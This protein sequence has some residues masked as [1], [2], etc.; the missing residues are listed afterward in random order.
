[1]DSNDHQ[2][3]IMR[4]TTPVLFLCLVLAGCGGEEGG[5]GA[6]AA[7]DLSPMDAAGDIA[8]PDAREVAVTDAPAPDLPDSALLDVPGVDLPDGV[9]ADGSPD[10]LVSDSS[11]GKLTVGPEGGALETDEGVMFEVPAGAVDEP[12]V[13]EV[14]EQEDVVFVSAGFQP[15][16]AVFSIGPSGTVFAVPVTLT[17]PYDAG[18]LPADATPD[19]VGIYTRAGPSAHWEAL[20]GSAGDGIVSTEIDHLSDFAAGVECLPLCYGLYCGDDGCGGDCK[21]SPNEFCGADTCECI[22]HP[23]SN[24]C[25]AFGQKCHGGQ[26]CTADCVGK[27]CGDDGCGGE[28]PGCPQGMECDD[29]QCVCQPDCAGRDC[30]PDGCGGTCTPGCSG[31]LYCSAQ[32]TCEC[33][34]VL[35]GGSCCSAGQICANGQCCAPSCAG[36]NCGADGCGADCGLC[37]PG[38][39][40]VDGVCQAPCEPDCD[41][42]ICGLDGCGGSCGGC[43]N[44]TCDLD[45][46]CACDPGT[47]P[48]GA[49]CCA[50]G[51]ACHQ[52]ACCA[53]ACAGKE[54]GPDGCGGECSSCANGWDCQTGICVCQP[55]CAG[56][57]CGL[58]GCGGTCAP[59]CTGNENCQEGTCTCLNVPCGDA[60]CPPGHWCDSG[61]CAC[62]A[63][64]TGKECGPD[65]CGGTCPPGCGTNQHCTEGQCF[66][67]GAA[68]GESCCDPGQGCYQGACCAP[69]CE[70]KICG[71]NG[72]GGSCG[73]CGSEQ[74]CVDGQC[75]CDDVVCGA[76]CCESFQV[77]DQ[78]ACCTPAC[79][80]EWQCGDDGCGGPCP[81][82]CTDNETCTDHACECAHVQC[83][84]V[85]C[86]SAQVCYNGSCCTSDCAGKECG[87]DG[88]GST[89]PPGCVLESETCNDG[90]CEC[91]TPLCGGACCDTW[92]V[93]NEG[94]CCNP[95]CLAG[96]CGDDGC[97]GTCGECEANKTCNAGLCECTNLEC[98]GACCAGNE[99]CYNSACCAPDCAGKECGED[100][101]GYTC[102]VCE[103]DQTCTVEG[104]CTGGTVTGDPCGPSSAG[105]GET[106]VA[107]VSVSAGDCSCGVGTSPGAETVLM[108]DKPAPGQPPGGSAGGGWTVQSTDPPGMNYQGMGLNDIPLGEPVSVT[109]Q[110]PDTGDTVTVHFTMTEDGIEDVSIECP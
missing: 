66:C 10:L 87:D 6:D 54:C 31:A 101:C 59:G 88:C 37:D 4:S 109:L 36:K 42:K 71:P 7:P 72:C 98:A 52:G 86:V 89:C 17:L 74:E 92:E 97:G 67:D 68:C 47:T 70:G 53:P 110:D 69:D 63:E 103:E 45:G 46:T 13:L 93:C 60:C 57:E 27:Q 1:M 29:G 44:A 64:C 23:C 81:P 3:R 9:A 38:V 75:T 16:G 79:F 56:K 50:P 25:C 48:C 78:G 90:L 12:V 32:G 100:G 34:V 91:S 99:V 55:A 108:L 40:C 104:L 19:E 11:E 58:D 76:A 96:Q 94:Q 18:A 5:G 15:V 33:A 105:F 35:C 82:G 39:N 95:I 62:P 24:G 65:K 21:C 14:I 28:C 85:C 84:D 107:A 61:Q 43:V 41:G 30:G 51:Q 106:G 2:E 83:G 22:F 80:A 102:G 77:C 73:L 26:C 49:N 20:G 8:P